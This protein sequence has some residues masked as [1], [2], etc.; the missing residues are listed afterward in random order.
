MYIFI[1][2]LLFNDGNI[3]FFT[4]L[5]FGDDFFRVSY[6]WTKNVHFSFLWHDLGAENPKLFHLSEK[7][8]TYLISW[9]L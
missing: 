3:F 8:L 7:S 2:I 5:L 9:K 6:L 4:R 1:V